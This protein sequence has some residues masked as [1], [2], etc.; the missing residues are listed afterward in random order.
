M[1]IGL[2]T[3]GGDCPGLNSIIRAAVRHGVLTYQDDM[4]GIRDSFNG[5]MCDP[6]RAHTLNQEDVSAILMRGGTILGTTNAGNPFTI[7][8][9]NHQTGQDL[10]DQVSQAYHKLGLD[11]ILAIGGDG[12]H[13]IAYQLSQK[14]MNIIGIPK[15]IDNDLPC[16]DETVGFDTAVQI[17]ADATTRLQSTAESHERVMILEVM[18]RHAGHIALHSGLAAGAHIILIPEIE[19]QLESIL[20]KIAERRSRGKRFSVIVVAEGAHPVGQQPFYQQTGKG[21]PILG[22]IGQHLAQQISDQS[23]LETRVTVLGHVQRGGLPTHRDRILG[24]M[25]GAKAV[26]LAHKKR[27]SHIVT[28]WQGDFREVPYEDIAGRFRGVDTDDAALTTARS[29]GICFGD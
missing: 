11:C 17:A 7:K 21:K 18:G 1:R 9:P 15:T 28:R 12:T 10:S 8:D 25:L 26:D 2:C 20:T 13:T 6:P 14:G 22:G 5:L 24:T 23:D 27:F 16:S 3:G 4:I 19:F 29:I